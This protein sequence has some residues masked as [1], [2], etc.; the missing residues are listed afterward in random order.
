M[1]WNHRVV[2]IV[3]ESFPDEEW[4]EIQEVYY[5]DA[6]QPC[7]YSN[8]CVGGDSLE[9]IQVQLDR[10]NACMKRP[11]LDSRTDFIGKF[12]DEEDE[13]GK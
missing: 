6:D 2:K 8:P 11:I 7:G 9:E 4:Y 12:L 5:N 1:H 13:C 10:F 3:D